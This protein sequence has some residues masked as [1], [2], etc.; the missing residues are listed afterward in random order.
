MLGFSKHQIT[1]VLD[2][3]DMIFTLSEV[4][5]FVEI[6]DVRHAQEILSVIS[7]VFKDVNSDSRPSDPTLEENEYDF[8]EELLDEWNEILQDDDL[9][10]MIVDNLSLSQLDDSLFEQDSVCNNS[11]DFDDDHVPSAVLAT[12]ED[13]NLDELLQ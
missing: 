4:Y 9:F 8:D 1:Q 7:E 2:N 10:D 5:K 6:W 12:V 11:E 3:L 13:M